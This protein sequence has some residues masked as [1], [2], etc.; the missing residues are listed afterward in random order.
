M[1][2]KAA[3]AATT[4]DD[5]MAVDAPRRSTRIAAQ[6]KTEDVKPAPKR[7]TKKRAADD[8]AAPETAEEGDEDKGKA[9]KVRF[10]NSSPPPLSVPDNRC[11]N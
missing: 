6:P 2:R 10:R 5:A 11:I 8:A 9:K 4:G 3:A 7:A 1:P